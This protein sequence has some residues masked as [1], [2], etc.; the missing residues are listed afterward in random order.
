MRSLGLYAGMIAFASYLLPLSCYIFRRDKGE[1]P[2]RLFFAYLGISFL[3]VTVNYFTGLYYINNL[4][5]YSFQFITEYY[6][7]SWLF[8]Q[9]LETKVLRRFVWGMMILFAVLL[10]FNLK[11]IL[12]PVTFD[13][14]DAGFVSFV[15]IIYC[16]LF[17]HRQLGK[18]QITFVHKTPW[19]WFVTALLLF[20]AG[21]FLV[22]L[23]TDYIMY[24]NGSL[25]VFLWQIR[26]LL[27]ILKNLLITV[28]IYYIPKPSLWRK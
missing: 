25:G 18:P 2:L 9:L 27:D 12:S 22:F 5:I 21:S 14:Y 15:I 8:L 16:I 10:L 24:Q 13:S 4:F 26:D 7:L 6:L 17:F 20:Y 11:R 19:F 3:F 28:G 1:R 23:T